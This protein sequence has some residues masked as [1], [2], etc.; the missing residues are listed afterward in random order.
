MSRLASCTIHRQLIVDA[1]TGERLIGACIGTRPGITRVFA[2]DP[3]E[4]VSYRRA[5]GEQVTMLPP[6]SAS[7]RDVD[8]EQR[9]RIVSPDPATP[10]RIRRDAPLQYQ[11]IRCAANG[12]RGQPLL[13][14][15]ASSRHELPRIVFCVPPAPPIAVSDEMGRSHSVTYELKN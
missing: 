11:E 15:T 6:V 1:R 12:R 4:L 14:R 3:P 8:A 9:P 10:Y 7:C 2:I 5:N 13:C